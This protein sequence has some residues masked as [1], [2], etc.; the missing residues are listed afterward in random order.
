MWTT[1][2][3]DEIPDALLPLS[4]QM[5]DNQTTDADLN[6][7]QLNEDMWISP[8]ESTQKCQPGRIAN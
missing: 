4:P 7:K 8:D 5:M 3:R 2:I 1:L 6:Y